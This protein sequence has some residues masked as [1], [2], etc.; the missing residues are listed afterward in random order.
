MD[1]FETTIK[2][3][4]FKGIVSLC[5]KLEKNREKINFLKPTK[6]NKSNEG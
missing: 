6:Q 2:C 3:R 5:G 1:T 4:I